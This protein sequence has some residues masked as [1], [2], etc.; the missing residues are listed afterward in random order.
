MPIANNINTVV[1]GEIDI[2]FK[3]KVGILLT[4]KKATKIVK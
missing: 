1:F 4:N 3:D 2:F